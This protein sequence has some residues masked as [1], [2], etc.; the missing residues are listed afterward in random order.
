ML[1]RASRFGSVIGSGQRCERPGVGDA[2]VWP[3]R[4]EESLVFAHGVQEMALVPDEGAVEEFA[5]AGPHPLFHDRV[6]PGH[7]DAAANN[8]DPRVGEDRVEQG[9]VL[10]VSVANEVPDGRSGVLKVHHEVAGRL[11]DPRR[12]GLGGGAQD[13]DTAAGMFD[14]REDVQAG[15]SEGDRFDEVGRE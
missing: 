2:L 9:R 12:G 5:A 4:V 7:L 6:H 10:A 3:V 14:D 15:P 11:G 1:S 13:P 8:R